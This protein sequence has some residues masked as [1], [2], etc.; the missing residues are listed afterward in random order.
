MGKRTRKG[1][2][3]EKSDDDMAE[4]SGWTINNQWIV[5]EKIAQ[6]GFGAVYKARGIDSGDIVAVKTERRLNKNYLEKEI[7]LLESL[8]GNDGFPLILWH[9]EVDDLKQ[10]GKKGSCY[11]LVMEFLGASLSDLF[12]KKDKKLSLK[13]VLMVAVQMISRIETLHE[14]GIVHRDIKPGNFIMGVGENKRIVYCIDFGLASYYRDYKG[15]HIPYKERG[16]FRGTHRYASINAHKKIEQSRR[17]D[18][19]AMGYVFVYFVKGILPWQNLKYKKANRRVIIGNKKTEVPL[20]ELTE[21]LP[22]AFSEYI[23]YCRNLRFEETPDYEYLRQLFLSCME[24]N[25]IDHDYE[26]D[27]TV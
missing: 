27:W 5:I 3:K 9:G 1:Y 17:D 12:Y 4:D 10:S 2:Q 19:E 15:E 14:H 21:G 20:E 7:E 16:T 11:V 22:N 24:Q 26:Y 8:Q 18:L 13:T 25:N 6:G 23:R